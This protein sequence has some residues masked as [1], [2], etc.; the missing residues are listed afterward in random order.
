M[1]SL[2]SKVWAQGITN[3]VLPGIG[4]QPGAESLGKIISAVLGIMLVVGFILAFLHLIFGAVAWIT[5]SGD[6]GKL[7]NA[8][9][10]ITQAIVGL[11]IMAALWAIMLLVGEFTGIGFPNLQIPT[12]ND[13]ASGGSGGSTPGGGGGSNS[14]G[15]SGSNR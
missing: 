1:L 5:S 7:E 4:S 11:I 13:A 12:V 15:S 10:R 14:G 3:P 6:K 2:V 9:S 8:Q